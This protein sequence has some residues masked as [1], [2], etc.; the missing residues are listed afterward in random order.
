VRPSRLTTLTTRAYRQQHTR[1]LRSLPVEGQHNE[2][3][4]A[5]AVDALARSPRH[6]AA[7]ATWSAR[8]ARGAARGLSPWALALP[9]QGAGSAST[10]NSVRRRAIFPRR[11]DDSQDNLA[12]EGQQRHR[13][14]SVA[15]RVSR[16]RRWCPV[17]VVDSRVDGR[18]ADCREMILRR[19]R[20]TR[21]PP[22]EAA[23]RVD[24][25]RR[26]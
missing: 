15:W 23:G 3:L 22:E 20:P 7:I 16:K 25:R 19:R 21:N 24:S 14:R 9:A 8:P 5:P 1:T 26:F 18:P 2:A 6:P 11:G 13:R 4:A 10:R 17:G 12:A